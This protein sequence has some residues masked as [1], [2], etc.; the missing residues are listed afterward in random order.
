MKKICHVT[1]VH[2][3]DDTRILKKQCTSLAKHGYEVH[4]VAKGNSYS[5]NSVAVIGVDDTSKNRLDRMLNF[6]KKIYAKALENPAALEAC[7]Y[8]MQIF[9]I[10]MIRIY[11]LMQKN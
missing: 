2:R 10:C 7:D 8:Y 5:E 4:L 3:S 11:Y 6:S 9:I 1:S